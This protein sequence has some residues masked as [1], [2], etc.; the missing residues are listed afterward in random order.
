MVACTSDNWQITKTKV[1]TGVQKVL[2]ILCMEF[3]CLCVCRVAE[4]EYM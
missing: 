4:M 2:N 3:L 1:K